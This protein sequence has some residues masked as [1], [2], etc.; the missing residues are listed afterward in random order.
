MANVLNTPIEKILF[1]KA[2]LRYYVITFKFKINNKI[3]FKVHKSITPL[4]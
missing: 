3:Y 4:Q 1:Y 2:I